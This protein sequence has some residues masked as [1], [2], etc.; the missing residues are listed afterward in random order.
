M[1]NDAIEYGDDIDEAFNDFADGILS[2]GEEIDYDD[3]V[4]IWEQAKNT[5]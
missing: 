1:I 3:L 4:D 2:R 5:N